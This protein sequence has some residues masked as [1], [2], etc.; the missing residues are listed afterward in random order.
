MDQKRLFLPSILTDLPQ[1]A[2]LNLVT[3]RPR[4]LLLAQ[5]QI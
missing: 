3:V 5:T 1:K 2:S 4:H